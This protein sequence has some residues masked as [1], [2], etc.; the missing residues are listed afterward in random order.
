MNLATTGQTYFVMDLQAGT[1]PSLLFAVNDSTSWT[2]GQHAAFN[3]T[4]S[5]QR[6]TFTANA[7]SN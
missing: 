1:A 6:F 7:Y 3:L 4:S 2:G 5:F